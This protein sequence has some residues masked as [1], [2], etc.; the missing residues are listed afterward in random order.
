MNE[1][2][3]QRISNELKMLCAD[4][5]QNANSGHPGAAMGLSDIAV[6]LSKY[7]VLNPDK[8]DWLNRDR[9]IFSG[10]HVSALLYALLHLWGFD[11]SL[12]DLKDFR[13]LDSKTPGHPEF[14]KHLGIEITTGPWG[15]ASQMQ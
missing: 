12:Q 10:G 14:E 5:V 8:P 13:K 4:M 3:Y 1:I 6:I 2:N 7:V 11:L 15:R 9:I